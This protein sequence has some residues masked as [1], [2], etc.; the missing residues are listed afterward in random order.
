MRG[1]TK[2]GLCLNKSPVERWGKDWGQGKQG[3]HTASRIPLVWTS[4]S[5]QHI[6]LGNCKQN[7]SLQ[8]TTTLDYTW[9][10]NFETNL[11]S[12]NIN[13]EGQEYLQSLFFFFNPSEYLLNAYLVPG[14]GNQNSKIPKCSALR[15]LL[16]LSNHCPFSPLVQCIVQQHN[17]TFLQWR[18]SGSRNKHVIQMQSQHSSHAQSHNSQLAWLL[19]TAPTCPSWGLS[20][21]ILSWK[22]S[23]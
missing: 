18:V 8:A 23:F 7:E 6:S 21:V 17:Q 15:Y 12:G 19:F 10:G 3:T 20:V 5:L 11:D 4:L 9:Q 1:W 22:L 16:F 14:T 2:P 13:A